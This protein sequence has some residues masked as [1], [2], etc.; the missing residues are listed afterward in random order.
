MNRNI[1]LIISLLSLSCLMFMSC[2]DEETYDFQG[3]TENRV[4]IKPLDNTVNGFNRVILTINKTPLT[5]IKGTLKLPVSST[6][7]V[8]EDINISF[9]V[10]N[11]LVEGYN[12]KN[13]TS[14]KAIP[15]EA[16]ELKNN[17]LKIPSNTTTSEGI[18]EISIHND[19][20]AGLTEKEYLIPIKIDEVSGN[21]VI[22]SNRNT[23]YVLVS[24][25]VDQDNI[26][27]TVLDEASRGELLT[28]DRTSW[29]ATS[30]NSELQGYINNIFDG[31]VNTNVAYVV[32]SYDDNTGFTI[33]MKKEY[34]NISGVR[35]H[36][37]SGR[38]AITSS[39]I[40][41]SL[42]NENWTYQGH[43]DNSVEVANICFYAP[44]KARYIKTIVRKQGRNVYIK[45]FN[46]YVKD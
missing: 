19:A 36:F 44:V 27:D 32:H 23:F 17:G 40:Y 7:P 33:D 2:G 20:I 9:S 35:Q 38:Y 30:V 21:A 12:A 31:N 8:K 13:K 1:R 37:Y 6:L 34:P 24:I 14:Y 5:I 22:S 28:I 11:S 43:F 45:E 26:W 10:D 41:T 39:D 29:S 18:V 25:S 3:D 42:D 15:A 16:V 46:I 4:Y